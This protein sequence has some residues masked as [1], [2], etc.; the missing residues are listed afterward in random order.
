MKKI[1]V[2]AAIAGALCSCA[3][4]QLYNWNGYDNAVYSYTKSN[5]EESTEDLIKVYE[6]LIKN[7]GSSNRPAPGV[8][9]DYGYLLLK[10]GE[11]QKGIALLKQE[12]AYYPESEAFIGRIIKRA[13]Q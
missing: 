13:E 1:L 3:P 9:A 11:K 8:C 2:L 12:I 7:F 5:S 4:A 10:K 6:K